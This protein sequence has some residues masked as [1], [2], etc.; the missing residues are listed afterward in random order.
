MKKRIKQLSRTALCALLVVACLILSSCSGV[1]P[2]PRSL[3]SP[4]KASGV[5]TGIED[6][7]SR[8]INGEYSFVYPQAGDYR[9]AC[10]IVKLTGSGDIE[11]IVFYQR[12]DTEEYHLNYLS[13]S[14]SKWRSITDIKLVCSSIHK[15]DFADLC[16]DGTKELLIGCNLYSEKEKKLFVYSK[17]GNQFN[18]I[19]QESYTDFAAC[20]LTDDTKMQL[21]LFGLS[22]NSSVNSAE[23][24]TA[25]IKKPASM[26]LISFNAYEDGVA[27]V[28]GSAYIDSGITSFSQIA[29]SKIN[30]GVNA[31]FA[32]AYKGVDTM[33]TEILYYDKSGKSLVSALSGAP[34]SENEHTRRQLLQNSRDIDGDGCLEIPFGIAIP[35]N[36]AGQHDGLMYYSQYKRFE[37]GKFTVAAT[38]Y[39]NT[40]DNYFIKLPEKWLSAVTVSI[41]KKQSVVDFYVYDSKNDVKGARLLSL[42]LQSKKDF[43]KEPDGYEMIAQTGDNIIAALCDSTD[44]AEFSI[45]T[46]YV[47]N[48]LTVF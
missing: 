5:L 38:G 8:A 42:K 2:D 19:A 28:L 1:F 41:D 6:A 47:K 22:T 25:L 34:L 16:G 27:A 46:E 36:T 26:Q 39:F 13:K 3:I 14:G 31:L 7:L 4:P 29:E 21:A 48:S 37:K 43:E 10:N 17:K 35:G 9:S 11:A 20:N 24:E 33:I 45:N 23:N 32:D 15:V 30:G 40:T 44:N 18:Q 12:K